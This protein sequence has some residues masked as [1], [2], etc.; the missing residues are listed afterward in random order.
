MYFIYSLQLANVSAR[1]PSSEPDLMQRTISN[2]VA[3]KVEAFTIV[4]HVYTHVHTL[5]RELLVFLV[6]IIK[7]SLLDH[8]DWQRALHTTPLV[9]YK[10]VATSTH[11]Y[12]HYRSHHHPRIK[13]GII[14]C[15]PYR[16]HNF[17]NDTEVRDEISHLQQTFEANGYPPR[18]VHRSIT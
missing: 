17:C 14:S 5:F 11:H 2:F 18:I 10:L 9:R 4:L 12:V 1:R 15:L 3:T 7:A 16:A 8:S 13:T 6:S